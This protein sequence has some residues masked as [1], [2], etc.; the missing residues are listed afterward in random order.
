MQCNG[1]KLKLR[2]DFVCGYKYRDL[3]FS[4]R[5]EKPVM[6]PL[7]YNCLSF[8]KD[9]KNIQCKWTTFSTNYV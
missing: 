4:E 7:N 3:K 2:V 5:I 6:S 1:K 9:T 8:E